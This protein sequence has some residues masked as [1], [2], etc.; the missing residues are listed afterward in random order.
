MDDQYQG[1]AVPLANIALGRFLVL[2]IP[3]AMDVPVRSSCSGDAPVPAPNT[4]REAGNGHTVS[5]KE[6][7]VIL[8]KCA[9]TSDESTRVPQAAYAK[10]EAGRH[11][12]SRS[13]FLECYNCS[14]GK[15]TRRCAACLGR[16]RKSILLMERKKYKNATVH[17]SIPEIAL[18]LSADWSNPSRIMSNP[19]S[20][21]TFVRRE[22]RPPVLCLSKSARCPFCYE[23]VLPDMPKLRLADEFAEIKPKYDIEYIV[24]DVP[25]P[26]NDGLVKMMPCVLMVVTCHPI[27]DDDGGN[28][29]QAAFRHRW[30]EDSRTA[31][32][33]E[34]R[35]DEAPNIPGAL[36]IRIIRGLLPTR[37][38]HKGHDHHFPPW[39]PSEAVLL[40]ACVFDYFRDVVSKM[41]P[42]IS[43]ARRSATIR[44]EAMGN[45]KLDN[46]Q[47]GIKNSS[48]RTCRTSGAFASANY[49][50]IRVIREIL[51]NSMTK[52]GVPRNAR[53]TVV[54][55]V[56]PAGDGLVTT[57]I[58][59][60][61][62]TKS[63]QV[64]MPRRNAPPA[65]SFVSQ[66]HRLAKCHGDPTTRTV[67]ERTVQGRHGVALVLASLPKRLQ[68]S[69][70]EAV[71]TI[72][73]Y[74][75]W[76]NWMT[77]GSS[78]TSRIASGEVIQHSPG[79]VVLHR[80]SREEDPRMAVVRE[81]TS[82]GFYSIEYLHD[83]EVKDAVAGFELLAITDCR[84][85]IKEIDDD[86]P[87]VSP[88]TSA[89]MLVPF[90]PFAC[91]CARS[92][93]S[94]LPSPMLNFCTSTTH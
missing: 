29:D 19:P 73:S 9:C 71:Q 4:S 6:V 24:R 61:S 2:L 54:L 18:L 76:S 45:R 78:D 69:T 21:T 22:G 10:C 42:F 38:P 48:Y 68:T 81:E 64:T 51:T 50:P 70:E 77:S 62:G 32:F 7:P 33:H 89:P 23:A 37:P 16:F 86:D 49:Q 12:S 55:P 65:R 13:L 92:N 44:K 25:W 88:A 59:H 1:F 53:G 15:A 11:G 94:H 47:G 58:P 52:G 80:P 93:A 35:E 41:R 57:V 40:S 72:E 14:P 39:P 3:G 8:Y 34:W 27:L 56:D 5:K 84:D 60:Y 31:T 17:S 30:Y 36:R 91:F 66:G 74:K 85:P 79:S 46:A 63:L 83:V 87:Q 28:M 67:L 43:N 26:N 82:D 20:G 75:Y 90:P